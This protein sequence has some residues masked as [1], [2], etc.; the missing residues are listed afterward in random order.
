MKGA[1]TGDI[2]GSIFEHY[3][4]RTKHF[5]LYSED[6]FFTDDTVMT[7]AVAESFLR[8]WPA[9]DDQMVSSFAKRM[10]HFGRSYPGRG[11]G[12]RFLDW[13]YS[14]DPQPYNSWGN[15]A[16]MRC[17][18]AGWVASSAEEAQHLGALTAYPTHNHPEAIFAASV[19][20]ELIFLARQ[21]YRMDTLERWARE[22]YIIRKLDDI[23]PTYRFSERS[24]DTMPP[25]LAAFF[26][27]T[28]FEDAIR[29]AIS[30][31]GDSDTIAAITGS[32][33]EAY[34]GIPD[35]IWK[36]SRAY[37]DPS[38]DDIVTKFYQKF[39]TD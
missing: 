32:I 9:S 20:A 28:S 17:S 18:A 2:I 11:Y 1:I 33:A 21:G 6:G 24:L 12:G 25:A 14:N 26:E 30:V 29:N 39:V 8:D 35:A 19:T 22:K 5:P 13:L 27:S 15:G 4:C 34:Y 38:L 36:E 7:L 31:G 23:R 37:L 3:N 16:P 10:G